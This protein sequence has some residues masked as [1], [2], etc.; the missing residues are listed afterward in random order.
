MTRTITRPMSDD[1][2]NERA[3]LLAVTGRIPLAEAL[4]YLH[5]EEGERS[6]DTEIAA[7]LHGHDGGYCMDAHI[8]PEM[9]CCTSPN[10]ADEPAPG[11]TPWEAF[12]SFCAGFLAFLKAPRPDLRRDH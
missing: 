8:V 12:K 9:A 5:S 3:S 1:D 7:A 6:I 11:L 4:R 2:R 10:D